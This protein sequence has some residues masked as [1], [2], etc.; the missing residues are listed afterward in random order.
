[1]AIPLIP[2]ALRF[3]IPAGIGLIT[4]TKYGDEIKKFSSDI[5]KSAKQ[6]TKE[7]AD[8]INDKFKKTP[9]CSAKD[10]HTQ[11]DSRRKDKKEK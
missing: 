4:G 9:P 3:L 10:M 2:I 6:M 5:S 11:Y 7:V 8:D 1:M